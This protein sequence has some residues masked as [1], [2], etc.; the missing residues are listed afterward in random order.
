MGVGPPGRT[1]R[2]QLAELKTTLAA[3]PPVAGEVVVLACAR[4]LADPAAGWDSDGARLEPVSCAGNLHSSIVEQWLRAGA[5][6]VL[7]LACPP[8]DCWNREGPTWAGERLF[9]DREAELHRRVDKDRVRLAYASRAE[10]AIGS[11]ELARFRAEL[12]TRAREQA[13]ESVDPIREC[14]PVL[15]A[16]E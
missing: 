2:D 11:A 4:G 8:R 3:A 15:E 16:V 9:H 6:G 14:D 5:A 13:L 7:V 10:G 1:G 12:A